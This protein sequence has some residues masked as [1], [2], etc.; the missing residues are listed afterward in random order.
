MATLAMQSPTGATIAVTPGT[1]PV[2]P[3]LEQ[4]GQQ[5]TYG[6]LFPSLTQTSYLT[7]DQFLAA[8]NTDAVGE[9]DLSDT[10]VL[11][12]QLLQYA[13]Q[14]KAYELGVTLLQPG[15]TYKWE[16]WGSLT[17]LIP[18]ADGDYAGWEVIYSGA[19][20]W[21][22]GTAQVIITRTPQV[23]TNPDGTT[24]PL[25]SADSYNDYSWNRYYSRAQYPHA[26]PA[27]TYVKLIGVCCDPPCS[28]WEIPQPMP[29]P[30][31]PTIPIDVPPPLPA[32]RCLPP[33]FRLG[34]T[35]YVYPP[36]GPD[37]QLIA[38]ADGSYTFQL[39]IEQ[40]QPCSD[41]EPGPAG[42]AGPQGLSIP[43]PAGPQGV[44]GPAGPAGVTTTII[45][46]TG[47]LKPYTIGRFW[48]NPDTGNFEFKQTE[49]YVPADSE[50]DTGSL[51]NEIFLLLQQ[52]LNREF[53]Q[54]PIREY[55]GSVEPTMPVS[56]EGV[57]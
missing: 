18:G 21:A 51:F 30:T 57:G 24:F 31:P 33:V 37:V 25:P 20:G 10:T 14:L 22:T 32:P 44:P 6:D 2:S 13:I 36:V 17:S 4:S 12:G 34:A 52:L 48:N 41:G 45:E 28:T 38:N 8:L 1:I 19:L 56:T 43:G 40:C 16:L 15:C 27:F 42:P 5:A 50:H 47:M 29:L 9:L 39:R 11:Q 23:Y 3:G 55:S 35:E 54:Q 7:Q 49:C 26:A 53:L 46:E